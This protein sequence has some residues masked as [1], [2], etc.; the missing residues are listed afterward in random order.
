MDVFFQGCHLGLLPIT[1]FYGRVFNG[2]LQWLWVTLP[3]VD[4]IHKFV[5]AAKIK[6]SRTAIPLH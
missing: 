4:F 3:V 5:R 2:P 1:G 6:A